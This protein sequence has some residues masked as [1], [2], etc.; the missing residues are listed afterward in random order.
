MIPLRRNSGVRE[1]SLPRKSDEWK[2]LYRGRS[3]VEREFGRLKHNFGLAF[4]RVR[5]IE[6]DEPAEGVDRAGGEE[7]R[8]AQALAQARLAL[9]DPARLPSARVL[10]ALAQDHGND[11]LAFGVHRSR[12]AR[13]WVLAQPW[14]AESQAHFQAMSAQSV[15]EQVRIEAADTLPFEQY[16]Q[17]Y[18]APERLGLGRGAI[19]PGLTA[20]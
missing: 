7:G 19:A 8:H 9:D 13:D 10:Q 2:R 16:R 3:A 1:S 20:A 18:I 5:G 11:F 14:D 4:L 17:Q 6:R 15:R 12:L